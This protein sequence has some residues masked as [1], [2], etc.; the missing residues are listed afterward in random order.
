MGAQQMFGNQA[1][2]GMAFPGIFGTPA[3]PAASPA[4][5]TDVE[6]SSTGAQLPAVDAL[7]RVRFAAQLAQLAAMGFS[8]EAACLAALQQHQGRVDAAIDAL[9]VSG[10]G[11]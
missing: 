11:A 8:N 6:P 2:N 1:G 4:T 3:L 7:A 9:L 10:N 5:D